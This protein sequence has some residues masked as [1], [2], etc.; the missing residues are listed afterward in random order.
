V[1]LKAAGAM[2][3]D[4]RVVDANL[5]IRQFAD[6]YLLLE[7][8]P[9][10]LFFAASDGRY[11]GMIS[12][13]NL[14]QIERSQWE[15]KTLR[16]VVHPLSDIPS[17]TEATPLAQVIESMETQQ[18]RRIT[19]LSPAGA[20]AGVIDRGDIVRAVAE[21]LK[22]PISEALIKRVKEEGVYPPGLPLQTL[23]KSL[24]ES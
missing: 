15:S 6:T 22:L 14:R 17:I 5:T 16:E 7:D 12:L 9:T 23:A 18:L 3:H 20:V 24:I 13:D 19:V 2:S 21:R 4:Y 10:P 1:H 11:R 8:P